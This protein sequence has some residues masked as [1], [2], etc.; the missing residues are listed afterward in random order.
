[1]QKVKKSVFIM[2]IFLIFSVS[3][4]RICYLMFNKNEYYKN[5]LQEKTTKYVY[6]T[7][8]PRGRILDINGNVLV[9]NKAVNI[10]VYYKLANITT[11]MEIDI[12]Y[13][14][15]N[16]IKIDSNIKKDILIDFY[17]LKNKEYA[18][19]LIT[20]NEIDLLKERKITKS[21]IEKL[22]RERVL[23]SDI[24]ELNEIDKKAAYFYNLMNLGIS[25]YQKIIY[26]NATDELIAKINEEKIPGIMTELSWERIYKYDTALNPLLGK[27]GSIPNEEKDY[28]LG[29]H[30]AL[31]DIVGISYLEKQYEE[32]LKGI[33][34]KY[35]VNNDNS[36][37]MINDAIKGNDLVLSIDIE[38]Q[39]KLE[40]I[41][42][43]EMIKAKKKENSKYFTDS[44]M[45]ISD[46]KTSELKAVSGL[47]II[48]INDSYSFQS[49]TTKAF[50]TSYTG[51]SIVKGA[52]MALG[53]KENII[54]IG[55]TVT[56]SCI[57]LYLVPKK[58]SFKPLGK[59]NDL[60]A[61]QNSSNYYQFLIAI[62]ITGNKYTKNMKLNATDYHFSKYR[63][64]FKEFGLGSL[65]GIDIP[66]EMVGIKGNIISD[67]LL[68][69]LA[70]GQYDTYT[71]I[72]Y[73]QYMNTIIN[74]GIRISPSLM[75]KISDVEG[76]TIIE[77]KQN[78]LNQINLE[79]KYF[80]RIKEGLSL[81]A[82]SGT[83]RGY[84]NNK[85]NPAGKTGT[86]ET[87]FDSN[88]DGL[89]D[90]I[91]IT[92]TSALY[93]PSNEPKYTIVGINPNISYRNADNNYKYPINRLITKQISNFLFDK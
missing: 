48:K 29:K 91:S 14:L 42:K 92:S 28:Y 83:G 87:A 11:N 15:A 47:K 18:S 46:A 5:K 31:N 35:V 2:F 13:K 86:S 57:K 10:I 12:A 37:T 82:I 19:N 71:P 26:E 4:T 45:I 27:I 34:A 51:G 62:G 68:L 49:I 56:D 23:D 65:T 21:E 90:M 39:T 60:K 63:N 76:N 25:Y 50:N 59:I 53:Y 67:D 93:F 72:E 20:E 55:H 70:I 54:K 3:I 66:N 33:K 36:L 17:L 22:K 44:F 64:F 6:G 40:E 8:S 77:N 1:M 58:C 73:L 88:N 32:Y 41:M 80:E 16:I 52:S 85:Y 43:N 78:I 7:S 74:K 84:I 79:T 61:L 69:N 30:Y 38:I 9:D 75:H 89:V 24:K 81:V